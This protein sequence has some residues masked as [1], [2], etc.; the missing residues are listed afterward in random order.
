MKL[1]NN[2]TRPP[3]R[4]QRQRVG[5]QAEPP[6]ARTRAPET[7]APAKDRSAVTPFLYR[8]GQLHCDGVALE[9]ITSAIGTPT[10]VYSAQYIKDQLSTLRGELRDIP[11]LICFAVKANSNLSILKMMTDG[12]AGLDLVSGGEML[13]AAAVGCPGSKVVFSG[14]GKTRTEMEAGLNYD[15]GKGIRSFHVESV[16]ELAALS[17]VAERLGKRAQVSL[18]FNPD[19]D[20]K[21]HPYISTGLKKN[22]FGLTSE[23]V[24]AIAETLDG[25]P[26][27]DLCGLSIHIGSQIL[28]L[29]PL[30]EA[31]EKCVEMVHKLN[32]VLSNPLRWADFGGGLGVSYNGEKAPTL[33]QYAAT[34]RRAYEKL[35]YF[36]APSRTKMELLLEPGRSISALSGALLTSVLYRKS[37]GQKDFIVID[38]A[39]N[40]LMRPALY[41]SYHPILP[42]RQSPPK[43]T[44]KQLQALHSTDVVGPVC[45]TGDTLA[46]GRNLPAYLN[47]GDGLAITASGAY[48]MSMASRYNSRA[49][50]AEVLVDG[51]HFKLIRSRESLTSQLNEERL[52]RGSSRSKSG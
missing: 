38:A 28:D 46:E 9:K 2:Q 10:Y 13:R 34:V 24:Y 7:T 6:K 36:H 45:E 39:M 11:A 3:K 5:R 18:R 23:E 40:D 20:A 26:M 22:K 48:G 49:L 21:T 8:K 32:G 43:G 42:F 44:P 29:A 35:P 50:P 1:G 51:N 15:H 14:V 30:K 31:F 47:Y 41:G 25:F 33:K 52:V 4:S 27:I 12:G 17:E 19:V 16:A 37:R